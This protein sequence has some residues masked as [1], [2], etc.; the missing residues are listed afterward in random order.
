MFQYLNILQAAELYKIRNLSRIRPSQSLDGRPPTKSQGC[1]MQTVA[2]Q[3]PP[4]NISWKHLI[5]PLSL[6]KPL[7]PSLLATVMF[8]LFTFCYLGDDCPNLLCALVILIIVC[9][10]LF[11]ILHSCVAV[12]PVWATLAHFFFSSCQDEGW[13]LSISCLSTWP[14]FLTS[15]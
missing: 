12:K 3:T 1:S 8:D 4:L 2:N 14:P 11:S 7:S 9:Q 10:D 13:F 6:I 5:S 15:L